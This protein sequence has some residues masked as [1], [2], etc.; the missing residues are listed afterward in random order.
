[1]PSDSGGNQTVAAKPLHLYTLTGMAKSSVLTNNNY[2]LIEF[3]DQNG[4]QLKSYVYQIETNNW[5]SFQMRTEAPANTTSANIQF[6]HTGPGI[7]D[8]Y[9]D[10]FVLIEGPVF[11]YDNVIDSPSKLG[12]GTWYSAET[13]LMDVL[14]GC[15]Y[16][17]WREYTLFDYSGPM[18]HVPMIWGPNDVNQNE[19]QTA[20]ESD[21]PFLL[22]FN[23][24]HVPDQAN[25]TPEEAAD[26]W[27]QLMAIPKALGS[28]AVNHDPTDWLEEFMILVEERNLRVDFITIHYYPKEVD[29]TA[30]RLTLLEIYDAYGLPIWVTEFGTHDLVGEHA[31]TMEEEA[32]FLRLAAL[33]MDEMPYV[34]RYA[35]FAMPGDVTPLVKDGELTVIGEAYAELTGECIEHQGFLPAIFRP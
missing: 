9:L 16:Y 33:Q 30:F 22:G 13:H 6:W 14:G 28:P 19:L 27:P 24:P 2:F 18:K 10:D 26:L 3:L 32:E 1:M 20:V 4:T 25:M 12:L 35:W 17:T 7:G 29:M 15:W 23:E 5:T 31:L 11:T 34:Q 8:M 21:S